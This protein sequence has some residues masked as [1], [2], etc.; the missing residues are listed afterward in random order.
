MT[1]RPSKGLPDN[2]APFAERLYETIDLNRLAVFAIDWLQRHRIPTTFENVVVAI[3][4]MFPAKFALEGYPQYPDAARVN[5]ALLQLRPKYRNWARGSVQKG[6]V[7][8]ETGLAQVTWVQDALTGGAAKRQRAPKPAAVSRTMDLSRELE[9][10][11][12]SPLFARWKEGNLNQG[13]MMELL[14]MLGAYAYTPARVLRERVDLLSNAA[15]QVGRKDFVEFLDDVRKGFEE[16]F[17][18][19]AGKG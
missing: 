6:F 13:N 15:S 10:L 18:G 8:T 17:R 12:R 9:P 4:R 3:F 19:S 14:D 2:V 16:H 11:E 5:R 1:K 7:L